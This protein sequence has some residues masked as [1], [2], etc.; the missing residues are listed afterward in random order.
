MLHVTT[1]PDIDQSAFHIELNKLYRI[2][3]SIVKKPEEE[4]RTNTS[5]VEFKDRAKSGKT[6]LTMNRIP[7]IIFT[8]SQNEIFNYFDKLMVFA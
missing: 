8:G 7:D 2:A 4:L 1:H 5:L 6:L 3:L